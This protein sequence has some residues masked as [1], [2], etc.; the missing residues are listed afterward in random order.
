MGEVWRAYDTRLKREVAIKVLPP[1]MSSN[2]QRLARFQQEAETVARLSHPNI[3]TLYSV[4][5]VGGL[6]FLTMELIR[7]RSL[8]TLLK[9]DGLPLDEVLPIGIAV[10][11]ALAAAHEKHVV[12]RDLKPANIVVGEAN[13]VKVLDFGLAKLTD[14]HDSPDGDATNVKPDVTSEGTVLGTVAY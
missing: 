11:E 14:T 5:E 10:A 13:V 3:V 8:D 7:G 4:E 9:P 2:P 12:H 1:A 6:Q